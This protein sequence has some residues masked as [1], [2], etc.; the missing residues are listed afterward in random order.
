VW[1]KTPLWFHWSNPRKIDRSGWPCQRGPWKT[2]WGSTGVGHDKVGGGGDAGCVRVFVW[3]CDNSVNH[4]YGIHLTWFAGGVE[5]AKAHQPTPVKNC[6]IRCTATQAHVE[7]TF[8]PM[9][10]QKASSRTHISW[11]RPTANTGMR[12]QPPRVTHACTRRRRSNSRACLL[13]RVMLAHVLSVIITS[14]QQRSIHAGPARKA[15]VGRVGKST[16]RA[17]SHV[18]PIRSCSAQRCTHPGAGPGTW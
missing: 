10:S 13:S 11:A 8:R 4:T 9:R 16:A 6:P 2:R 1:Q 15:C 3:A 18:F 14:G 12:T 17:H 5:Q 7:R